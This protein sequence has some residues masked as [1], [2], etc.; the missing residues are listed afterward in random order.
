MTIEEKWN[1]FIIEEQKTLDSAVKELIKEI[2]TSAKLI[3]KAGYDSNTDGEEAIALWR[4]YF[5]AL[6]RNQVAMFLFDNADRL[7]KLLDKK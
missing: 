1:E 4:E 6:E 5:E 3:F 7:N 2:T